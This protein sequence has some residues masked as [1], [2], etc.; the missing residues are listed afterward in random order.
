MP[1][2]SQA[3]LGQWAGPNSANGTN[4]SWEVSELALPGRRR[5]VECLLTWLEWALV[6]GCKGQWAKWVP[7]LVH[8]PGSFH[9]LGPGFLGP[10]VW[11]RPQINGCIYI[12]KKQNIYIYI[13]IYIYI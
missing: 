3:Q 13:Y 10:W 8:H 11:V 2:G 5:L 6:L 1:N 9:D 7:G 4:K 12:Y